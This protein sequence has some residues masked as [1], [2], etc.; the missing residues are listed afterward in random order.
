MSTFSAILL[1]SDH[2][3]SL[4][5]DDLAVVNSRAADIQSYINAGGGLVA[6]AEDG[7]RTLAANNPQ[8]LNFAY[9]PFLVSAPALSQS[10]SGYTVTPFGAGLGLSA[11]DING[12]ASHNIFT[13]FGPMNVVDLD[14]S[15]NVISLA[16]TGTV[17][18]PGTFSLLL[19]GF[20]TFGL[21]A[22]RH[23]QP[24]SS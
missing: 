5:G 21:V 13:S 3:G 15:N 4:T 17:P 10:E 23:R 6:L 16:Y 7:N 24:K 9:L 12:N 14:A 22:C 8:P 19:A 20:G 11:S 2:G 1:P 18:E